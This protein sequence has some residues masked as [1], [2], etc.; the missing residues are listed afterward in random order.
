M[1][2]VVPAL[3]VAAALGAALLHTPV[4]AE[5]EQPQRIDAATVVRDARALMA[6]GGTLDA[7]L[8]KVGD[9]HVQADRDAGFGARRLEVARRLHGLAATIRVALHDGKVAATEIELHGTGEGWPA[10]RREIVAAGKSTL[11]E[12]GRGIWGAWRRSDRLSAWSGQIAE[13][14]GKAPSVEVPTDLREHVDV[15]LSPT[16][17][18]HVGESFGFAGI[19]PPGRA[20]TTALLDAER[21]DLLRVALRSPNPE[22]RVE[23]AR[24]LVIAT[25]EGFE[26]DEADRKAIAAVRSDRL[27]I[28]TCRGCVVSMR[29]AADVIPRE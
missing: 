8:E 12:K 5:D 19:V 9:H 15:L 17:F 26:L 25:R 14:L 7:Y 27:P 3:A 21:H 4:S 22:G 11:I 18:Y 20:A 10:R 29:T 6:A 1:R 28:S 24:A 13:R 23:A 2:S 16:A